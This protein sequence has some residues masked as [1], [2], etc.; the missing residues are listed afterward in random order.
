M[1]YN[2]LFGVETSTVLTYL[3][4]YVSTTEDE[5]ELRIKYVDR[6]MFYKVL[7]YLEKQSFVKNKGDDVSRVY[8]IDPLT[9]YRQIGGEYIK[10]VVQVFPLEGDMKKYTFFRLRHNY[11]DLVEY[12]ISHAKEIKI[13]RQEYEE[14]TANK[15]ILTR[16]RNRTSFRKGNEYQIDLTIVNNK[17]YEIEIE[18]INLK[19][20]KNI[21]KEA[22]GYIFPE[23]H[24]LINENR[25]VEQFDY[26]SKFREIKPINIADKHLPMLEVKDESQYSITNKLDGT[27]YYLCLLTQPQNSILFLTNVS[28]IILLSFKKLDETKK[29]DVYIFEVEILEEKDRIQ[30]F[31]FDTI[32]AN[33]EVSNLLHEERIKYADK[34][35]D[36]I[37][38]S[39]K[40]QI[41]FS[42]RPKV[43]IYEKRFVN[44]LKKSLKL[45]EDEFKTIENIEK[46]NDGLIFQP[47][48]EN[49]NPLKWKFVNKISIDFLYR[50]GKLYSFN[51]ITKQT[52]EFSDTKG[53]KYKLRKTDEVIENNSIIETIFEDG[54]FVYYR[55]RQDKNFPNELTITARDTF[56][57]MI[58]PFHLSKIYDYFKAQMK[59]TNN[60]FFE[61]Y[62]SSKTKDNIKEF[63]AKA[64]DCVVDN[65]SRFM[66]ENVEFSK[67]LIVNEFI[68]LMR[69]KKNRFINVLDFKN[70]KF[71]DVVLGMITK[72]K[73]NIFSIAEESKENAYKKYIQGL[74]TK[75]EPYYYAR[76]INNNDIILV[77]LLITV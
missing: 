48:K 52:E 5:V 59:D 29:I 23:T 40:I 13:S 24:A 60:E 62:I 33:K 75:I 34:L 10:K 53:N 41:A 2:I 47:V 69:I 27:K 25:F 28:D 6:D 45:L 56:K 73:Q 71:D 16:S 22:L 1:L 4:K 36:I 12:K 46:M 35:K 17:D 38:K 9:S 77:K 3:Q 39:P 63:G 68:D 21:I 58:E 19:D 49:K 8:S 44:S 30:I 67:A 32:Y 43:F 37:N 74:K 76:K 18:I 72:T 66:F 11:R 65:I 70:E 64:R 15:N 50:D 20:I 55:P 7:K 31:A 26:I 61:E 14:K 54:E 42:F 57:D 51:K